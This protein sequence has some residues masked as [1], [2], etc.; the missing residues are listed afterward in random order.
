MTALFIN[1]PVRGFHW[2]SVPQGLTSAMHCTSQSP[3]APKVL[4]FVDV[5]HETAAVQT[6]P[7]WADHR[8][9]STAHSPVANVQNFVAVLTDKSSRSIRLT[10]KT[11]RIIH[12]IFLRPYEEYHFLQLSSSLLLSTCLVPVDKAALA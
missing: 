11:L 1:L 8:M 3:S 4:R 12:P 9:Q 10:V 6:Q 7:G 5:P 2:R